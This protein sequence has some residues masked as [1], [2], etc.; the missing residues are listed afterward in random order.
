MNKDYVI[1]NGELYHG[2][3]GSG[4]K[5]DPNS[6]RQKMLRLPSIKKRDPNKTEDGADIMPDGWKPG[7]STKTS[8]SNKT[9]GSASS[10]PSVR[11]NQHFDEVGAEKGSTGPKTDNKT[12]NKSN[13]KTDNKTDNKTNQN[14]TDNN[15]KQDNIDLS[16]E[17][18]AAK[19]AGNELKKAAGEIDNIK[20]NRPRMDLSDKS[21]IQLRTEI[22]R[23]EAE[24][25]YNQLFSQPSKKEKAKQ[26]LSNF[27]QTAGT[28]LALGGSALVIANEY[29]KLKKK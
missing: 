10:G 28:V 11:K 14:T 17:A 29:N 5:I 15:K 23:E 13:N 2:G 7:D 6:M 21:I 18:N 25:K 8:N 24:I 1:I 20:V 16:K 27:L 12:D 9:G 22:A 4:R 26:V 19:N 3:P